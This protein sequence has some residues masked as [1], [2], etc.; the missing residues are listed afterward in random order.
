MQGH[1]RA[2]FPILLQILLLFQILGHRC[3]IRYKRPSILIPRT[4]CPHRSLRTVC[5]LLPVTLL[6]LQSVQSASLQV[7]LVFWLNLIHI[8]QVA[9]TIFYLPS[10]WMM[11]YCCLIVVVSMPVWDL[12]S[13]MFS[14]YFSRSLK[15]LSTGASFVVARVVSNIWV[16]T[17]VFISWLLCWILNCVSLQMFWLRGQVRYPSLALFFPFWSKPPNGVPLFYWLDK[18]CSAYPRVTGSTFLFN[19]MWKGQLRDSPRLAFWLFHK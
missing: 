9:L 15:W 6:S 5:P 14:G 11:F 8:Q 2:V 10:S 3:R 16:I 12:A 4:T 1:G 18:A 7:K 19:I 13:L 17:L